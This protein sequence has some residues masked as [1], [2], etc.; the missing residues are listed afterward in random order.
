[1]ELAV[2]KRKLFKKI[3]ENFEFVT[4][5]NNVTFARNVNVLIV[6]REFTARVIRIYV[7]RLNKGKF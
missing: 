6:G 4:F 7:L 5:D 1:M 2:R 3:E